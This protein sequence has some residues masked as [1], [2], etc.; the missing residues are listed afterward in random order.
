MLSLTESLSS[1]MA[2]P[3]SG[4][5]CIIPSSML[6]CSNTSISKRFWLLYLSIWFLT[7]IGL[8]LLVSYV[9]LTFVI[10]PQLLVG[11]II[12]L[13]WFVSQTDGKAFVT[14]TLSPGSMTS[15]FPIED[16]FPS[17]TRSTINHLAPSITCRLLFDS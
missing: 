12:L 5:A 3:I 17:L 6:V 15:L 1:V 11:N 2:T 8:Q 7:H 13:F 14:I 9:L 4:V 16:S 10:L